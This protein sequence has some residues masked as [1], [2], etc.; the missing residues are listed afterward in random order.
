MELYVIKLLIV[1]LLV[2]VLTEIVSTELV[3]LLAIVVLDTLEIYVS[4]S[5]IIVPPITMDHEDLASMVHA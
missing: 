1:A 2:P 4:R 5:L 3:P